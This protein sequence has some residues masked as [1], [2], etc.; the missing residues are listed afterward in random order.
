LAGLHAAF[1][2][3]AAVAAAA[4]P[5]VLRWLPGHDQ[6]CLVEESAIRA[7]DPVLEPASPGAE[8]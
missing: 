6:E 5:P 2:T 7:P 3:A 1:L 8:G 4:V